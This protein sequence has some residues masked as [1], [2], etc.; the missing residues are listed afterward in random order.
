VITLEDWALI[1]RLA[2]EGVPHTRI[3]E[4]LEISRTTVIKAVQATSPPRYQRA[5]KATSFKTVEPRVRA[6]LAELPDLPA[7]PNTIGCK[8][9]LAVGQFV[10]VASTRFLSTNL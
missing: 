4:R 8:P 7:F 2:A 10:Q 3:A 9:W 6:L 1:R 5:P